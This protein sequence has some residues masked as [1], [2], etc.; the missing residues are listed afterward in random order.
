MDQKEL[1]RKWGEMLKVTFDRFIRENVG[2]KEGSPYPVC[3]GTGDNK[4]Q[5]A[6]C[7]FRGTC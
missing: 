7:N 5:C 1:D 3:Y 2:Y 6:A 4:P